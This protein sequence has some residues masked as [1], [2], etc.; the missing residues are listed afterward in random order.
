MINALVDGIGPGLG[1]VAAVAALYALKFCRDWFAPSQPPPRSKARIP[2]NER[3]LLGDD[4]RK[5]LR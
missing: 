5:C 4:W 3:R 2:E 1:L